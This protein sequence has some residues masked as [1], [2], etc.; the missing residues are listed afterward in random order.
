MGFEGA[1][2]NTVVCDI[3]HVTQKC[4]YFLSEGLLSSSSSSSSTTTS[5]FFTF[6]FCVI[7]VKTN[8]CLYVYFI[9]EV[10]AAV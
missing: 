8:S 9:R 6:F 3:I 1:C 10:D 2:F 7:P 5:S 4:R